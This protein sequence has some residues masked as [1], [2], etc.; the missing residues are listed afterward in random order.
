MHQT[1]LVREHA[2]APHQ[3]V[4]R[5]R[6]PEH[7][8]AQHVRHDLLRLLALTLPRLA[9]A[10]Q[11]RVEQRHVVVA[12]NQVAQ[13]G[14]PLVHTLHHHFVGKR[15]ADV[16]QLRVYNEGGEE[17]PTRSRNRHQESVLVSYASQSANVG[18]PTVTRPTK[19]HPAMEVWTTG[20]WSASSVS[21]AP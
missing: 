9:Y 1:A 11:I 20:M 19:R 15:V 21:K 17:T 12:R 5:D 13:R 4:P 2:V 3:R 7:L 14:Q 8:H 10:V 18:I 16:L 6:L